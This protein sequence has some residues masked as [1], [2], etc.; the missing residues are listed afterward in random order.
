MWYYYIHVYCILFSFPDY[1]IYIYTLYIYDILYS[2]IWW[3]HIYVYCIYNFW[4][5][6]VLDKFMETSDMKSPMGC[7]LPSTKITW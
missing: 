6:L 1:M 4:I 5:N 3:I 2:D 7:E